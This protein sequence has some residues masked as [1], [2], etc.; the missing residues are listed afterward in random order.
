[1]RGSPQ[2]ID[3]FC[4]QLNIVYVNRSFL[5]NTYVVMSWDLLSVGVSTAD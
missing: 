2:L 4:V 5:K 1:M 3:N